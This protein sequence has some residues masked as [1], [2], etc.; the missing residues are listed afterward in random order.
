VAFEQNLRVYLESRQREATGKPPLRHIDEHELYRHLR[1]QLRAME[2]AGEADT[3]QRLFDEWHLGKLEAFARY[4]E[5]LRQQFAPVES[6]AVFPF[7][8]RV[9]DV[10]IGR[11][12]ADVSQVERLELERI[13]RAFGSF[14]AV[15]VQAQSYA[16]ENHLVR[17]ALLHPTKRAELELTELGRV[18]LRL[19]GKDAV[20]WIMTCEVVQSTGPSDPW[21]APH[22][23]LQEVMTTYGM[24]PYFIDDQGDFE[25]SEDTRSRLVS[26]GVLVAVVDRP[27]GVALEYRVEPSMRDVVQAVLEIGPWHTAVRALLEDERALVLPASASGASE[28]T[29]EQ[30]KLIVH[31][32]RN[33]LIPVR[34]DIE[35]LRAFAAEHAQQARIDSAKQGIARVLDFVEAMAQMS[36]LITEPAARYEIGAVVDEAVGWVDAS[37]RVVRVGSAEAIHVLAPRVRFARAISNVVGNALQATA[38][39][40]PVRV[41]ITDGPG[42]V[43]VVVEDSGPGI[44]VEHR[45]RVFLE[46]VTMR[47]DGTGS[48][49]GLA[50]AKRVVEG[51]LHGKI[52]R[53][54]SELGGARFVIEVPTAS[55][56]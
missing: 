37:R 18:F 46:G 4:L 27:G 23:L 32:V 48:G 16:L 8:C 3:V 21:H 28:A 45:A 56:E 35:A 41:S 29:I 25:Y 31:E 22:A 43:C 50:F 13:V 14:D 20:R 2:R 39:G 10:A 34:H 9:L 12:D 44:A 5:M 19:R 26:L 36:E 53:E 40:Q 6:P 49:F 1:E 52:W 51:V 33:A 15:Y 30:T 11:F 7:A 38:A 55:P 54:D 47:P 17:R 24:T 42:V